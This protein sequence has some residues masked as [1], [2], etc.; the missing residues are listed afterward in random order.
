MYSRGIELA[1]NAFSFS[2][3]PA[4]YGLLVKDA[5]DVFITGNRFVRN[6]TGMFFDNAPQAKDGR[7]EVRGNLVAR[8]DVG[9]AVQPLTRRIRLWENAWVGNR[10]QVQVVGTGSA[11]GNE[12]TVDGR[13][14]FWSDAV[15][16]DADG[17]GVSD[18]PYRLESTYEALADRH[19]ALA[20]FDAT[21]AADAIDLAAR[22]F[23]IFT[24]RPKLTDTRP[25]TEA[26]LTAWTR[27]EEA[28][29]S[30]V[31]LA[32]TGAALMLLTAVVLVGGRHVLA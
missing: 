24:P 6:A 8:N 11:D 17:D 30:G 27:T 22:L 7:V 32:V 18:L 1:G 28:T 16:Y 10:T 13:G 20:F 21:P 23:P 3:G 25:L 26:P 4:A 2:A 31:P 9:I 15:L 5:D 14:N 29:G 12:W 19:P